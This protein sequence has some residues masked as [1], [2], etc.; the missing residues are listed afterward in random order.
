[1]S[2]RATLSLVLVALTVIACSRAK[3]EQPPDA[4]AAVPS[5]DPAEV[6]AQDTAEAIVRTHPGV[7]RVAA[8]LAK[9]DTCHDETKGFDAMLKCAEEARDA[10]R[11]GG[12]ALPPLQ[13]ASPCGREVARASAEMVAGTTLYLTDTAAWLKASRGKLAGR[14]SSA[15]LS[16]VCADGQCGGIPTEGE[17]KYAKSG[18]AT[19]S[20]V[21][22]TKTLFAC[23]GGD[24][25]CWI[26]K[27]AARLG[28]ACDASE[29]A[30]D[31]SK[32]NDRLSVRATGK[33]IRR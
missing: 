30:T 21:E 5:P 9:F 17:G 20:E 26:Q 7:C 14:L 23:G 32:P 6:E 22:C 11:A 33:V 13:P 29:N 24:N 2:R 12:A 3:S 15:T 18:Y 16:T 10:A 25:V 31:P 1:M 4:G 27:V 8:A 28:V 19:V